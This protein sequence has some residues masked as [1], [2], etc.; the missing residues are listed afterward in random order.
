MLSAEDG[1]A[2]QSSSEWLTFH[3][4]DC[5]FPGRILFPQ[6]WLLR[7]VPHQHTD[8]ADPGQGPVLRGPLP[9]SS[10][11][12]HSHRIRLANVRA[13]VQK[14]ATTIGIQLCF[15]LRRRQRG[16]P[17]GYFQSSVG[18][19]AQWK[20]TEQFLAPSRFQGSPHHSYNISDPP[21]SSCWSREVGG[22]RHHRD[23]RWTIRAIHF[24]FC[25]ASLR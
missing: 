3:P 2:T 18:A 8:S 17:I 6:V 19:H 1:A 7:T 10:D 25:R 20:T 5:G 21:L 16:H 15:P 11:S 12:H 13:A 22:V 14:A 9:D 23:L 4:S 24:R